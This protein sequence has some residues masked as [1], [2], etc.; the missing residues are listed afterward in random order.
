MGAPLFWKNINNKG[1]I[2]MKKENLEGLRQALIK[3][4]QELEDADKIKV[5]TMRKAREFAKLLEEEYNYIQENGLNDSDIDAYKSYKKKYDALEMVYVLYDEK[6][7][8]EHKSMVEAV[9]SIEEMI[10]CYK[11]EK[12]AELTEYQLTNF[13]TDVLTMK[14]AKMQVGDPPLADAIDKHQSN[15]RSKVFVAEET[16]LSPK[17]RNSKKRNMFICIALIV[18][19]FT[20]YVTNFISD[21]LLNKNAATIL[22]AIL[23]IIAF[24]VASIW[25]A[26]AVLLLE[27]F[28]GVGF[29]KLPESVQF[30]ISHYGIS[31]LISL[32]F[33]YVMKGIKDDL[34]DDDEAKRRA[35]SADYQNK[36][37]KYDE[38]RKER[39]E[40][41]DTYI[42]YYNRAITE[43]KNRLVRA[44]AKDNGGN[45]EDREMIE[46]ASQDLSKEI[47]A[48]VNK[49]KS[50]QKLL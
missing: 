6:D 18:L 19:L 32:I 9:E 29:T 41:I 12:D 4:F 26:G 11:D 34:K 50:V 15:L 17:E 31:V 42:I 27:A 37:A 7:R 33:I 3:A 49:Y 25:G 46:Q 24:F 21:L 10:D 14:W 20:P 39:K 45:A 8:L 36:M 16:V 30:I 28:G 22:G 5:G 43:V 23:V 2:Q 48:M 13:V 38:W 44:N 47:T 35:S 1:V 40:S